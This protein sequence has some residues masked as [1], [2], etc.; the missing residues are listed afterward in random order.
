MIFFT[1]KTFSLFFRLDHK[2]AKNRAVPSLKRRAYIMASTR[3]EKLARVLVKK[4][5]KEIVSEESFAKMFVIVGEKDPA[6]LNEIMMEIMFFDDENPANG[7]E[8]TL[9]KKRTFDGEQ[10]EAKHL[11]ENALLSDEDLLTN[12]K[13]LLPLLKKYFRSGYL[14]VNKLVNTYEH[15]SKLTKERGMI[16]HA[17]TLAQHFSQAAESKR[18]TSE[19]QWQ[20][21]AEVEQE[22]TRHKFNGAMDQDVIHLTESHDEE[23]GTLLKNNKT[24]VEEEEQVAEPSTKRFMFPAISHKSQV[25]PHFTRSRK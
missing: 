24:L 9:N 21:W 16:E 14:E 20:T 15:A 6:L 25:S 5:G 12:V 2:M 23:F 7:N 11:D 4:Y 17:Y 19:I 18:P 8:T 22:A 10:K 13:A 1:D 3:Q